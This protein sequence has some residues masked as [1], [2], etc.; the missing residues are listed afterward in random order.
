MQLLV[1]IFV[2]KAKGPCDAPLAHFP[3]H[4]VLPYTTINVTSL[5]GC[6]PL[7]P[8]CWF[9]RACLLTLILLSF[10]IPP[11]LSHFGAGIR[12]VGGQ[13]RRELSPAE[14]MRG[15]S[16]VLL[17]QRSAMTGRTGVFVGG[18]VVLLDEI[19][20]GCLPAPCYPSSARQQCW[21][22]GGASSV[23][24]PGCEEAWRTGSPLSL[25]QR[26]SHTPHPQ[27]SSP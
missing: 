21:A 19:S 5:K 2:F 3:P 1:F 17:Y 12:W 8:P 25:C 13:G 23:L 26:K 18:R 20:G 4:P 27:F 14:K 9:C 24:L 7:L 6:S 10:P 22:C 15:V 16:R 11:C